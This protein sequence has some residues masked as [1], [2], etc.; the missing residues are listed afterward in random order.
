[1]TPEEEAE[2][3]ELV[4]IPPKPV[5]QALV[6]AAHRQPKPKPK[7]TP[8][9]LPWWAK[10]PRENFTAAG[11]KATEATANTPAARTIRPMLLDS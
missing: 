9:E 10:A 4:D 7:V 3:D 5:R 2:L 6:K 1:M 8:G 11:A